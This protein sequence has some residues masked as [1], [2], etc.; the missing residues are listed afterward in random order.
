MFVAMSCM[1]AVHVRRLFE[2]WIWVYLL[3][4]LTYYPAEKFGIVG[5]SPALT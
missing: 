4:L 1:C 3:H 2:T 5:F